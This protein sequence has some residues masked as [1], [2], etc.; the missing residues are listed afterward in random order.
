M[1]KKSGYHLS[2]VICKYLP[3]V[4]VLRCENMICKHLK[5]NSKGSNC[6]RMGVWQLLQFE[7]VIGEK[8]CR[9]VGI[10]NR[11]VSVLMATLS[12]RHDLQ[13]FIMLY[14]KVLKT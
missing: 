1:D 3:G 13:H 5:Y 6:V 8:L 10:P 9:Q 11:M 2:C 12:A 7:P 14:F 4:T